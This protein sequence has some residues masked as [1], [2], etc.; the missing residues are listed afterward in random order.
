MGFLNTDTG[1]HE[2]FD[3]DSGSFSLLTYPTIS[4]DDK[5]YFALYVKDNFSLSD[6]AYHEM[7]VITKP[8]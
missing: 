8:A 5:Q 3:F 2:V 7:S 1:N 4:E 6:E